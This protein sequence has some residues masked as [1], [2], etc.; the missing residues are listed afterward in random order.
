MHDMMKKSLMLL[1]CYMFLATIRAQVATPVI[2]EEHNTTTGVEM[3]VKAVSTGL[4]QIV[5]NPALEKISRVQTFLKNTVQLV[6]TVVANMKMTRQ[7]IAEE[8]RIYGLYQRCIGKLNDAETFPDKW[9]YNKVIIE[10][11]R[12]SVRVFEIFDLATIQNRGIM[13]DKGR[14]TLIKTALGEIRQIRRAMYVTLRR[15][16]HAIF[17]YKVKKREIE[18]FTRIFR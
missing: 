7:L 16:N 5:E 12:E 8:Q 13:D 17:R 4:K 9:K 18:T 11:F 3:A 2:D 1:A 14:I 6:S 15:A 10:L